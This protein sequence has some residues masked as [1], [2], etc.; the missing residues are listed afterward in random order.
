[1]RIST[2]S[3]GLGCCAF[4]AFM[5]VGCSSSDQGTTKSPP[6]PD[7]G[8]APA[9]GLDTASVA[10]RNSCAFVAGALPVDT[11]GACAATTPNPIEHIVIL[12]QENRSFDQY[13]GHLPGHGQDD[14]DVARAG[15][16]NPTDTEDAGLPDGSTTNAPIPWHHAANYCV[17]DT[18]HG[19]VAS[20]RAWH[21]GENN[22]FGI[23]NRI[24]SDPTGQRAL[25][26]YDQTDIPFYYDLV[27]TFA[28]SDR[29]FCSVLGPTYPNRFYLTAATS[30]G[31][32]TT[33]PNT[34]APP[35]VPNIY[36]TLSAKGVSW[37]DYKAQITAA[38]IY[39][40]FATDPTEADHFVDATQFA[41]DAAA[42]KLPSVSFID[43]IFLAKATVENDEHPPA[44]IQLGEKFVY[45][46]VQALV[47]SPLW[48]SS[49]LFITYDEHGGYY[50]H[51]SPPSACVPDETPPVLNPEEGN[52]DRL[53]FRVPLIVVSPYAKRHFVS[54]EVH[55][56]TSILR[57][58]ESKF[59]LPA[60]TKRDANSDAMF[61][62]FDFKSPPNLSVPTFSTP[63][64]SDAQISECKAA[65]P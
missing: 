63:P 29:Y 51:V 47:K 38:L 34:L 59:G 40:D 12:M 33:D 19:W 6:S 43:P 58:I 10:K 65:F 62:L 46:Q 60:F 35:G 20:H 8:G 37:K 39:P 32:V 64:V 36:R 14:V 26:Y 16:S 27:S 28:T 55:S 57:F 9:C 49:A 1:M 61:D 2:L 30:F 42:G 50:D 13:F 22:G 17:A 18:D 7:G 54:H 11:L 5:T 24:A 23:I 44:D 41:V 56:H 21:D 31:I 53:G 52:F 48:K 45:D 15:A 3:S 4:V 25:G